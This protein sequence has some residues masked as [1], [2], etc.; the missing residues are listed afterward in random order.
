MRLC[1]CSGRRFEKTFENS[2]LRKI[3]KMQPL[4]VLHLFT[5]IIWEC[6]W[7]LTLEKDRSTMH[8]LWQAMWENFWKFTQEKNLT[9]ATD[10]T[11]HL[12]THTICKQCDYASFLAGNLRRHLKFYSGEKSWKLTLEHSLPNIFSPTVVRKH[13]TVAFETS[14]RSEKAPPHSHWRKT[15]QMRKMHILKSAESSGLN[16]G[17]SVIWSDPPRKA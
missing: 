7:K 15:L 9:H 2:F 3:V 14:R 17:D 11:S 1:M 13:I 10:V 12:F 16:I 4:P 5:Q 8:L 6:I